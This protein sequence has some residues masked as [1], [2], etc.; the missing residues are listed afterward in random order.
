MAFVKTLYLGADAVGYAGWADRTAMGLGMSQGVVPLSRFG[1]VRDAMAVT[2][3]GAGANRSVDVA[4]GM[5]LIEGTDASRQGA[6]LGINDATVNVPLPFAPPGSLP[7][8]DILV[9]RIVDSEYATGPTEDVMFFEFIEGSE[10][11][12]AS[13]SNRAGAPAVPASAYLLADTLSSPGVT[14]ITNSEIGERRFPA[15]PILYGDDGGRYRIGVDSSGKLGI[16][17][18]DAVV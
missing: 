8:I 3:R 12:G 5:V 6:Y 1:D 4:S 18:L 13:L 16:D 15:G 10:T 2:Q 9:A 11:A 7:R 17:D 14:P